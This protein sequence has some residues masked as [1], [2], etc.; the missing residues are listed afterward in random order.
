MRICFK[1]EKCI[2]LLININIIVLLFL[3]GFTH[4]GE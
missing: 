1:Y 4:T 2:G 3:I